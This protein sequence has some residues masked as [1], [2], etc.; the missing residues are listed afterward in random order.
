MKKLLLTF[1]LITL[2]AS[3]S[4]VQKLPN[5]E[6]Q[7]L[8]GLS[9]MVDE[10]INKFDRGEKSIDCNKWMAFRDGVLER[11]LANKE[12]NTTKYENNVGWSYFFQG[13]AFTSSAV[14]GIS[15]A[16][17]NPKVSTWTGF[18]S[19][20]ALGYDQ[21]IGASKKKDNANNCI[22]ELERLHFE[23]YARWPDYKCPKNAD[24]V[25]AFDE[26]A[27]NTIKKIQELG[28]FL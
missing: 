4:S 10:S 11:I 27:K 16:S 6:T 25:K 1:L 5:E 20:V 15:G 24:E 23:F 17:D 9:K 13:L 8:Q 21:L 19:V 2:L 3:C 18:A 26:D 22:K 12:K 14:A 7:F 28:C